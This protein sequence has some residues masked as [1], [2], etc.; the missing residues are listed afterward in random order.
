[1]LIEGVSITKL[2]MLKPFG[3]KSQGCACHAE[4]RF[5]RSAL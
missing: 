3:A 4:A 1:M 2:N 5:Q